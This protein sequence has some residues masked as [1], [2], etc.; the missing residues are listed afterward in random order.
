MGSFAETRPT[1]ARRPSGLS[2]MEQLIRH[3]R[4]FPRVWWV[5]LSEIA[6]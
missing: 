3:I 2:V 5:K 4:G 6:A 1:L